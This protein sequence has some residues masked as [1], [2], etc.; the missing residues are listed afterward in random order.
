M[1]HAMHANQVLKGKS[2]QQERFLHG[3]RDGWLHVTLLTE[4]LH[5]GRQGVCA[6]CSTTQP[7][8]A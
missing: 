2:I 3:Q 1:E 4:R 6:L 5:E 7:L 8:Y